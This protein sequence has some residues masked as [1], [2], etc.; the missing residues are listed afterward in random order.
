[1]YIRKRLSNGI[2]ANATLQVMGLFWAFAYETWYVI[3]DGPGGEW[4]EPESEYVQ[5]CMCYDKDPVKCLLTGIIRY[6]LPVC[7]Y[8]A[9]NLA[10]VK[11]METYGLDVPERFTDAVKSR[12]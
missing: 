10:L 9:D 12:L 3:E 8:H 6:D 7:E 4:L 11:L 5:V 1:M 2:I